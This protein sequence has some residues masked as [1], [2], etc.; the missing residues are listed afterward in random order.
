MEA[1][2]RCGTPSSDYPQMTAEGYSFS[3]PWSELERSYYWTYNSDLRLPNFAYFDKQ[4]DSFV[5]NSNLSQNPIPM[6][7]FF[8]YGIKKQIESALKLGLADFISLT[9]MGVARFY[10]PSKKWNKIRTQFKVPSDWPKIYQ[11]IMEDRDTK[12]FYPTA[13]H[14]DLLAM[15]ESK[16]AHENFRYINRNLIA[17]NFSGDLD[18]LY[19]LD[20]KFNTRWELEG[21]RMITAAFNISANKNGCFSF[22]H[23]GQKYYFDLSFENPRLKDI[24]DLK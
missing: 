21:H 12:I 4:K 20:D 17:R 14:F 18:V 23:E 2:N 15:K 9:D 22:T 5:A 19:K 3:M 16:E 24:K 7:V 13:L 1:K 6:N 11:K 10:V 8:L